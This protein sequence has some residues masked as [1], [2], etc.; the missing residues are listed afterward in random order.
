M[1]HG[2][3]TMASQS[4]ISNMCAI[5]GS[6]MTNKSHG[7]SNTCSMI[8]NSHAHGFWVL[9]REGYHLENVSLCILN[10]AEAQASAM[11]KRRGRKWFALKSS[12]GQL[13]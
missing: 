6:K 10:N 7:A 5:K 8:H 9:E 4:E 13:T 1:R 3:V 11:S 12:N 2:N